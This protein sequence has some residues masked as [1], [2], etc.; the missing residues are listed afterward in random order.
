[1]EAEGPSLLL[2]IPSPIARVA[3]EMSDT[4]LSPGGTAGPPLQLSVPE[5]GRAR[6]GRVLQGSCCS[7]AV[8][9][10]SR[11]A[12]RSTGTDGCLGFFL[13]LLTWVFIGRGR[14]SSC[15]EQG[16]TSS[17]SMPASYCSGFSY[18]RARGLG[19]RPQSLWC[20][21]LSCL[22]GHRIFPDQGWNPCPLHWQQI[23][24]PWTTRE[25]LLS[26]ALML[27]LSPDCRP[28]SP[29]S[30]AESEGEA[31]SAPSTLQ[32]NPCGINS[33]Q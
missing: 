3:G 7:E 6:A 25:V 18:C 13:F 23:L 20:M 33:S 9:A 2:P 11:V 31:P 22:A 32:M 28:G 5:C 16:L 14:C 27:A 29:S 4:S 15:A 24:N 8:P 26:F 1:M 21:R 30:S 10:L 19:C 12:V 17:C